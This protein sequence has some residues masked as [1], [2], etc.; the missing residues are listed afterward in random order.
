MGV[1]ANPCGGKGRPGRYSKTNSP[2]SCVWLPGY[3]G[4]L[5]PAYGMQESAL[6]SRAKSTRR[7][8]EMD[9]VTFCSWLLTM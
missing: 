5:T 6:S 9:E 2:P 1:G 7:L 4:S 8:T 3:L